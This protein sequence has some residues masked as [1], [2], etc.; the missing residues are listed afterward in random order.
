MD[1]MGSPVYPKQHNA[2]LIFFQ[3]AQAR[4]AQRA[5]NFQV[6][7]LF[8][9]FMIRHKK[10][11]TK[12]QVNDIHQEI[13]HLYH[14]GCIFSIYSTFINIPVFFKWYCQRNPANHLDV[15]NPVNNGIK[16]LST[17]AGF[18]PSLY[19]FQDFQNKN[20]TNSSFERNLSYSRSFRWQCFKMMEETSLPH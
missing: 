14:L 6:R 15:Q 11:G 18:L 17:G 3:D 20:V 1:P 10:N 8:F 16:Y 4:W 9:D 5:E 13:L 12:M 19:F 2:A 7:L